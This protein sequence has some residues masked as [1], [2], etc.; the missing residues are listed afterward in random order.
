MWSD[1]QVENFKKLQSSGEKF[2]EWN[3]KRK[4]M[5]ACEKKRGK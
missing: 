5:N 1:I 3:L 4:G 2:T